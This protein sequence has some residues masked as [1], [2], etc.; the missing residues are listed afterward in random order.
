MY[1]FSYLNYL[2]DQIVRD[3]KQMVVDGKLWKKD[4]YI[5]QVD[6]CLDRNVEI[7]MENLATANQY[8]YM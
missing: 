7:L 6:G 2:E 4:I 8:E 3:T 5:Q 1:G